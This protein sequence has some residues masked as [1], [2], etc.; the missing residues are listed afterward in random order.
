MTVHTY[1]LAT[2][3]TEIQT[4]LNE[5]AAS[6]V[7]DSSVGG[8]LDKRINR[9]ILK[10]A[11]DTETPYTES[12]VNLRQN[13]A[14]YLMPTDVLQP[15]FL[16][17]PSA[18]DNA[19]LF[20]TDLPRL[21]RRDGGQISWETATN[22][23]STL[24]IPFSYDRF[25]VWPPP[26][27]NTSVSFAYVP[28]PASLTA[29]G[30]TTSFHPNVQDLVPIYATYLALRKHDFGKA[31]FFLSEYKQ[32]LSVAKAEIEKTTS[33]R[34]ARMSLAKPFDRAHASPEFRFR[35]RKGYY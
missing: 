10:V 30:D 33:Y 1:T 19:R 4:R 6:G 24:F 8:E 18:W 21:D 11:I 3:R 7:W 16:Y 22:G 31:K 23:R 12:T 5:V 32:R 14:W 34:P 13:V 35:G 17:G 25:I 2:F 28:V 9:A 15:L 20:P 27:T 26:D 29:N